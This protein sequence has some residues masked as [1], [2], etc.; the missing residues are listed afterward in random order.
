M[1]RKERETDKA[2]KA[3]RV[4]GALPSNKNQRCIRAGQKR[5]KGR[6]RLG[7][8]ENGSKE[9]PLHIQFALTQSNALPAIFEYTQ[10]MQR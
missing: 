5:K 10:N 1:K 2:D 6:K 8:R 4:E 7:A 9:L 3:G